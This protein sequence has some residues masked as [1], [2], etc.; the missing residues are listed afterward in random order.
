MRRLMAAKTLADCALLLIDDQ[1]ANLDLLDMLLSETYSTIHRTTDPRQALALYQETQPDLVLV[2]LHM[3]HLDG[4]AVLAQL[5]AAIAPDD[6]VPI[7]V[8]TA[9]ITPAVK[10]RALAEGARDFLTK[11]LDGGEVLLRVRN[12]LDTRLL[13]LQLHERNRLL[14]A[15]MAELERERQNA[16]RLLLNVLPAPVAD[17]LRAGAYTIADQYDD[18]TVLF[19]DIEQFTEIAVH[20]PPATVVELLN[21]IF[22]AFDYLV[23]AHGLEKIKTIGDAYMVVG[24]VPAPHPDPVGAMADLAL[25]MQWA[26]AQITDEAGRPY[27]LRIG[28]HTGPVIAGVLGTTK[29]SYD[30]W[31]DTVNTASRM[32]SHGQAGTI[33]VS[34]VVYARLAGRYQFAP[35]GPVAIKGKGEMDTYWLLG[36]ADAEADAITSAGESLHSPA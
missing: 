13:H 30:L 2:D 26:I 14:E 24:G 22:S 20:S 28:I 27:R 19:A 29:L 32:E 4:F 6:Y 33:Q 9:D 36:K 15:K 7:L 23:E 18:A 21:T 3:P 12:L 11:P 34:E 5:R 17:R 31:G 8:L 16:E 25:A 1:E 35:R 10:E